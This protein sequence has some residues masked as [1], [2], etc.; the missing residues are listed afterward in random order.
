MKFHYMPRQSVVS[1]I[2]YPHKHISDCIVV[3]KSWIL[4]NILNSSRNQRLFP[5]SFNSKKKHFAFTIIWY[6]LWV[7]RLTCNV[8]LWIYLFAKRRYLLKRFR[9]L[10]NILE[11]RQL[12]SNLVKIKGK[13]RFFSNIMWKTRGNL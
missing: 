3:V 10:R 12:N 9:I 1:F 8:L 13:I 6:F 5:W 11:R 2:I 7:T 4:I